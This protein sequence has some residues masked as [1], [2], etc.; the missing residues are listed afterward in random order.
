MKIEIKKY[1]P[2][3]FSWHIF[4]SFTHSDDDDGWLSTV[5]SEPIVSRTQENPANCE[6]LKQICCCFDFLFTL[7]LGIGCERW[8]ITLSCSS[9]ISSFHRP[10]SVT[11]VWHRNI[12]NAFVSP[13]IWWINRIN[14]PTF[15]SPFN[16]MPIVLWSDM[17]QWR[18][19]GWQQ[20][21]L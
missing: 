20:R 3:D 15:F 11:S 4:H 7:D 16:W 14:L 19:K 13:Q 18:K 6:Q 8:A 10:Q 21:T 2:S 9:T 5:D 12:Q 17:E 1:I